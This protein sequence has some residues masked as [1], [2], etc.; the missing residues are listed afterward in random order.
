M[1]HPLRHL[2]GSL[3]LC[4]VLPLASPAQARPALT[5]SSP[6]LHPG[7][8][9]PLRQVYRGHGCTGANLS[10]A[11]QW[12]HAPAGTRSYA[13]TLHDP[14]APHPGGWWHWV[15]YD[16]PAATTSLPEGAG[17]A[18]A[19]L[20]PPGAHQGRNDFGSAD[21]GGACPPPGDHA[22]RYV[23]TVH[24]LDV[25]SLGLPAGAPAASVADAIRSHQIASGQLVTTFARR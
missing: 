5:V 7:G 1:L 8:T 3:L 4:T 2:T 25:A 15:V 10:P 21:Y 14:D 18:D 9:L 19:A 22:H 20:L 23:L 13:I 6:D 17:R 24:A 12:A 11:L 16:L